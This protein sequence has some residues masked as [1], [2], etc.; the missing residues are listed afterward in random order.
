MSDRSDDEPDGINDADDIDVNGIEKTVEAYFYGLYQSDAGILEG[1]F[2]PTCMIVGYD[3]T[4]QLQTMTRD[5]FLSFVKT[6]PAPK[7]A[8]VAFDMETLSIDATP[9]TAQICVRDVYIGRDFIDYLSMI[10]TDD[11]WIIVAKTF[12]SEA[13]SETPK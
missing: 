4:G 2:H 10:R 11:G 3:S 12:Y 13:L 8:G 9:T 1:I 6:V 5:Q 7:D